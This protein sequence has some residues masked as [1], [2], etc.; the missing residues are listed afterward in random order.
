VRLG[1]VV[2][3]LLDEDGL[4][5]ARTAEEADLAALAGFLRVSQSIA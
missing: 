1:D 5:D 3:E 4:A 2:D